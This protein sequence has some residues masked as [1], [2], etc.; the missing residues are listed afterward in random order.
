[1][2]ILTTLD[3]GANYSSRRLQLI[4]GAWVMTGLLDR[5]KKVSLET[6][7]VAED[8]YTKQSIYSLLY[9]MYR[10][11]GEVKD[12]HGQPYEFTFNTWGY[13]WPEGWG[14]PPATARDPF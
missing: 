5:K 11:I 4:I 1:M 2:D 13:S 8:D 14:E 9:S 7:H 3:P 10:T 6:G 12:E